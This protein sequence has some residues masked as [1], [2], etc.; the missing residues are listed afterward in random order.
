MPHTPSVLVISRQ[1]MVAALVGFLVELSGFTPAFAEP[2]EAP[3]AALRR[4][5]PVLV[6][7][8]D[9][10]LDEAG[11]DLFFALA[12]KRKVALALFASPDRTDLRL[13][14]RAARRGIPSFTLP[15]D[16]GRLTDVV[17]AAI[18]LEWWRSPADRRSGAARR[19]RPDPVPE[20]A[21]AFRDKSGRRWF[22][23][24]RR[25]GDRRVTSPNPASEAARMVAS[26]REV[27]PSTVRRFVNEDGEIRECPIS[28]RE[29]RRASRPD[30][31]A[32]LARAIAVR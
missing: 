9:A 25:G 3:E 32:Q 6:A 27:V 18:R 29:S 30:L 15:T 26:E 20:G 28:S 8:L 22:V 31:E 7:L 17:S 13:P 11:S 4:V 16:A 5:R 21:S 10:E 24:D 23:F 1:P 14:E 19:G 2:G 12:A